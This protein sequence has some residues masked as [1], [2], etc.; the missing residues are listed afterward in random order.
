[1]DLIKEELEAGLVKSNGSPANKSVVKSEPKD[2]K[3]I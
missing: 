2:I 1:M 3:S